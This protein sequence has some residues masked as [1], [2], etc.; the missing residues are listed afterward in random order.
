[1]SYPRH[2]AMYLARQLTPLSLEEIGMHFDGRDHST[3]LHAQ[4]VIE[5]S[6]KEDAQTAET[7][8][9]LTQ[10]LLARP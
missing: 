6:R 8:A 4:Q 2:I 1:M 5:A 10:Q 7:L 9:L 3:I